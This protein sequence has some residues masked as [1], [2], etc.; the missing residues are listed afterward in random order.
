[1]LMPLLLICESPDIGEGKRGSFRR[2]CL[3]IKMNKQF[4]L[5]AYSIDEVGNTTITLYLLKLVSHEN[6][7]RLAT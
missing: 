5:L 1:M 4:V 7:Y 3:Q 2:K 6:F